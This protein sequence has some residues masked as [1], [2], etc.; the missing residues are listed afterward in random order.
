[1]FLET[2]LGIK[3]FFRI[4]TNYCTDENIFQFTQ[5][6]TYNVYISMFPHRD[7]QTWSYLC[8][9][10]GEQLLEGFYSLLNRNGY[11][12]PVGMNNNETGCFFFL[13]NS[14]VNHMI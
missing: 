1:M 13:K 9:E 11:Y 4:K 3:N 2:P 5:I 6:Y 10:T 8:S 7:P 14:V 12:L